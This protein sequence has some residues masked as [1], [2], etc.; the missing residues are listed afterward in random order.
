M[1]VLHVIDAHLPPRLYGGTERVAW[2]LGKELHALGHEVRFLARSTDSNDFST[3]QPIQDD[4]PL[5]TQVLGWADIVHFH[6]PYTGDVDIPSLCT[7]QGH[8]AR[9]FEFHR[10]SVFVS[11]AH[12]RL[13][14]SEVFVYN[15]VAV[16]EYPI[17]GSVVPSKG[18]FCHFLAKAAWKVKNVQGAIDISKLAGTHL[19]VLGGNRINLKMGFR[20]T[21]DLHV[22]FHGMVGGEKK[23]KLMRGSSGLLFPVLWEEPF[24][25]AMVESLL[26]GAPVFGTPFGSLPEIVTAELG[27]LSNNIDE[28]ADSI[29]H[30]RRFDPQICRE[31]AADRFGSRIM[32]RRY[33]ALYE[34]VLNG[35]NLN[36]SRPRVPDR[37]LRGYSLES[38]KPKVTNFDHGREIRF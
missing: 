27:F 34:K 4:V 18:H 22:G 14:G 26:L 9:G 31:A 32:A 37:E 12:A 29:R 10:N 30:A 1:R 21:P 16:D 38:K 13:M 35:A 36:T 28:L 6:Y 17:E 15:G 11:K 2:W 19:R 20:F 3:F 5:A 25:I 8:H 7:V 24:G 23:L 33:L